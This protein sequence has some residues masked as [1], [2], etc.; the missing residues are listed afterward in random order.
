MKKVSFN[1][2]QCGKCCHALNI[3]LTRREAIDWLGRGGSVKI[4][5][6]AI[7]WTDDTLL[8]DS[9]FTR[10]KAI[11]FEAMSGSLAIRVAVTLVGHYSDACPN[12]D[13]NQNCS[14]YE[15]RP[16]TCR[17][18]P[19][20]INPQIQLNPINKLC[21]KDAWQTIPFPDRATRENSPTVYLIDEIT[22]E[23]ITKLHETNS[24]EV[25]FKKALCTKLGIKSCSL[26]NNGYLF[27]LVEHEQLILALKATES[28]TKQHLIESEPSNDGWLIY[29]NNEQTLQ[30]LKDV[31]AQYNLSFNL[32][33]SNQEFIALI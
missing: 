24:N 30:D 5:T 8:S 15:Q 17:I 20:E 14:I 16:L 3:P 18:Y 2:T 29:S 25:L 11:T 23:L 6:E 13:D 28:G 10:K 21:P 4:L 33:T 12:L 32:D 31:G 9:L 27:H 1:C 26:S 19:F 22:R 7:P